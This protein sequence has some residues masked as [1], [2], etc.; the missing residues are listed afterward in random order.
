MIS[1]SDEILKYSYVEWEGCKLLSVGTGGTRVHT[2]LWVIEVF[3]APYFLLFI[4]IFINRNWAVTR[5]QYTITH[6][7]YI[8]QHKN[9]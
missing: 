8:A 2:A 9:T 6:K 1:C 3:S 4:I 5:W 7:Q